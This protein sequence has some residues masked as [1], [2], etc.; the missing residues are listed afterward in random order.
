MLKILTFIQLFI[1]LTTMPNLAFAGTIYSKVLSLQEQDE[2]NFVYA[3]EVAEFGIRVKKST[4]LYSFAP[5]SPYFYTKMVAKIKT[6]RP[7]DLQK[8]AV[9]QFIRGCYFQTKE[10]AD[11]GIEYFQN[12]SRDFFGSTTDF[13]HKQWVVDSVDDDPIYWS[14]KDAK[15]GNRVALYR[16]DDPFYSRKVENRKYVYRH[17]KDQDTY[18]VRDLPSPG[19]NYDDEYSN[20]SMEFRTCLYRISDVPKISDPES[21]GLL[22]KAIH[23]F[24]WN[25]SYIYN[26]QLKAFEI[27]EQLASYC[28]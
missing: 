19:K 3:P 14:N 20:A 1:F 22:E 9:V 24:E 6:Y 7:E 21:K 28:K 11:G 17:F 5:K 13:M 4:E 8:F 12:T 26:Y 18:Y 2:D 15:Y 27:K 16:L 10:K 25:H 23:C